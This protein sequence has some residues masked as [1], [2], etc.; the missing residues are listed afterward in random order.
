[1]RSLPWASLA[2]LL[3][4]PAL[5]FAQ[6]VDGS[7]DRPVP[8]TD[9]GAPVPPPPPLGDAGMA[10][11]CGAVTFEGECNGTTLLYCDDQATPE[12]LITVDCTTELDTAATCIIVSPKY[13]ADCAAATG[14]ECIFVDENSDLIQGFCQ[15]TGAGCVETAT[16]SRCVTNEAC[17]EADIATCRGDRAVLDC[18]NGQPWLEDCVSFGGTCGNGVCIGIPQGGFCGDGL[19]C[20]AGLECNDEGECDQ[21]AADAGVMTQADAAPTNDAMPQADVGAVVAHPDAAASGRPDA[22]GSGG[23]RDAG[24][25]GGGELP[26]EKSSCAT[27]GGSASTLGLTMLLAGLAMI[28]R[29]NR[30]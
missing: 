11:A 28:S 29:R 18:N 25:T 20:A 24:S 22:A 30:R 3:C 17:V 15:G 21:P 4:S 23:V 10:G 13:G 27:L 1:M 19:E 14:H 7:A 16:T 8:A 6:A 2:V 12:E 5:A 26:T 9:G